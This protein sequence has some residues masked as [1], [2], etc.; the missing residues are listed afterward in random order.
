MG[1]LHIGAADDLHGFHDFVSLLL[2]ALLQFLRNGEHRGGAERVPCVHAHG[3]DVLN[4]ADRDH[5]AVRIPDYLQL[6]LLPAQDGLL[7]QNLAHQGGLEPS[8]ADRAELFFI[9]YQPAAGAAHGVGRAQHHRV[10]QPVRNGQGLLHAVGHL[11]PGHLYPQSVHGVLKLNAVLPPLDGVHLDADDL[12]L[13]LVQDAGAGQ[14]R[15]E[16]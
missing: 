5:I 2:Q 16:V 8:G 9:I 12:Y 11:A 1:K 14:L 15:T 3:I 7:H 6:Q 13:V 10:S 4:E